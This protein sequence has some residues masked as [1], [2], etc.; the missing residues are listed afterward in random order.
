MSKSIERRLASSSGKSTSAS[1]K[2]CGEKKKQRR[3]NLN[4]DDECQQGDDTSKLVCRFQS[5]GINA[6]SVTA[7]FSLQTEEVEVKVSENLVY[8]VCDA[9][10]GGSTSDA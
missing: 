3:R 5:N 2:K 6:T 7:N 9:L 8:L 4:E 10:P 1:C